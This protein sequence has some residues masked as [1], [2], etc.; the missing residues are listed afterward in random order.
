MRK[1]AMPL[2]HGLRLLS[3]VPT[4]TIY[5]KA[6][7]LVLVRN[8]IRPDETALA[9][10]AAR[11]VADA[12]AWKAAESDA[13][14]VSL[15][16]NVNQREEFKSLRLLFGDVESVCEHFP[17]YGEGHELTYFRGTLPPFDGA[18]HDLPKRLGELPEIAAEVDT[19][20]AAEGRDASPA[21]RWKLT[22]N[23]YEA[24]RVGG[25]ESATRH[26]FPWHRD[27]KANGAATMILNLGGAG[28]LQFG[29]EPKRALADGLRYAD[30]DASPDGDGVTLLEELQLRDG[31]LLCLT[32]PA[33]WE[34]LHRVVPQV[35]PTEDRI[36]LVYGCW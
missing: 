11:R 6:P 30:H 24:G 28:T 29:E 13:S 14:Q 7:G 26:G 15:A 31:D 4:A 33:R 19:S 16:H 34:L 22:L 21:L 12:A 9:F 5:P 20:R 3:S 27:L 2:L 32:G 10:D 25:A 18:L 35:G 36:T 23:R 17:S 8:F 1:L